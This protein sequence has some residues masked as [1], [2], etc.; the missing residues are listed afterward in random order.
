MKNRKQLNKDAVEL[1]K[2]GFN[3]TAPS[4]L[5]NLVLEEFSNITIIIH[6]FQKILAESVLIQ[7]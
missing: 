1:K 3:A 5:L 6:L 7:I 2:I 4:D